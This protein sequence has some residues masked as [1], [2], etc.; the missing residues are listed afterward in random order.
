LTDEEAYFLLQKMAAMMRR[1]QAIEHAEDVG[2]EA[3]EAWVRRGRRA[4][5]A[6]AQRGLVIDAHRRLFGRRGSKKRALRMLSFDFDRNPGA[7]DKTTVAK[8]D[9]VWGATY[10]EPDLEIELKRCAEEYPEWWA[11]FQRGLREPPPDHLRYWDVAVAMGWKKW[12]EIP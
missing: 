12:R 2:T 5:P 10:S 11:G 6:R 1:G 4:L 9:P 3:W 7:D 8:L